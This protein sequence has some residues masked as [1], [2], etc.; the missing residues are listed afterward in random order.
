MI[1]DD[2]ENELLAQL[3]MLMDT[4]AKSGS[5][6]DSKGKAVAEEVDFDINLPTQEQISFAIMT[7]QELLGGGPSHFCK[8]PDQPAAFEATQKNMREEW[9]SWQNNLC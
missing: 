4:P 2:L 9:S 3:E 1:D 8:V 6:T 5:A 7:M